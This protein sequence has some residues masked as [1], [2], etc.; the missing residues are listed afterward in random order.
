[1]QSTRVCTP[2][3]ATR[4]HGTTQHS[5]QRSLDKCVWADGQLSPQVSASQQSPQCSIG[6]GARGGFTTGHHRIVQGLLRFQEGYWWL[7]PDQVA[8]LWVPESPAPLP[9]LLCDTA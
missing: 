1:M 4:P 2:C 6:R 5:G 7:A 9:L 8:S 3:S